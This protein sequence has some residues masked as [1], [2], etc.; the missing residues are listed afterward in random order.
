MSTKCVEARPSDR[1][2]AGDAGAAAAGVEH[3]LDRLERPTFDHRVGDDAA[4][5]GVGVLAVDAGA[6]LDPAAGR[7]AGDG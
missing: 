4:H 5:D 2:D 3:R 7:G 1:D 6:E